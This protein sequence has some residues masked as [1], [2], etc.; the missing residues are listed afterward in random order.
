LGVEGSLASLVLGH[1]VDGVLLAVL[2]GAVSLLNLGDGNLRSA[3]V[4]RVQWG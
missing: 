2:S 3:V 1:L 4:V